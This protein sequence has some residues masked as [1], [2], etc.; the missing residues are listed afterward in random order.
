MKPRQTP[1]TAFACFVALMFLLS[2]SIGC[3]GIV[4]D[5]TTTIYGKVIDESR[6]PIDSIPIIVEAGGIGKRSGSLLA[7]AYTDKEGKYRIVV[8]VPKSSAILGIDL[9]AEETI[10]YKYS[11]AYLN[12]ERVDYCCSV[13]AGKKANYDFLLLSR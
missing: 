5:R 6:Q 10:N 4:L 12:G 3:G 8:E 9:N 13:S 1:W 2:N 7:R 11:T